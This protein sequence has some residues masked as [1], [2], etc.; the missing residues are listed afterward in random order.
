MYINRQS[1]DQAREGNSIL[2]ER[3]MNG[4]C[5]VYMSYDTFLRIL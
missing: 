2:L 1:V 5:T 4:T 3:V